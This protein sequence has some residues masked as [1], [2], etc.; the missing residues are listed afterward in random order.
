MMKKR[1][2]QIITT[3]NTL[4]ICSIPEPLEI[5]WWLKPLKVIVMKY[6]GSHLRRWLFMKNDRAYSERVKV[7]WT[8]KPGNREADGP[9]FE[10]ALGT[11]CSVH[12]MKG[13]R[14]EGWK[15]GRVEK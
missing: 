11:Q 8:F 7:R 15:G 12:R 13:R 4:A 3:H 5:P 1:L 14:V 2:V 6:S 10:I 9:A